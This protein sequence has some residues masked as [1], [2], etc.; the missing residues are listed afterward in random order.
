MIDFDTQDAYTILIVDDEPENLEIIVNYA[1]DSG[2]P[3]HILQSL[4]AATA[5]DIARKEQPHLVITDW[6]M[7]GENGIDFVKKLKGDDQTSDI[8]VIMCTGVMTSSEN[9]RTAFEAGAVDFIRKPID[10]IELISR[11]RSMLLLA[12]SYE[13][14]K[15]L[16]HKK[17]QLLS[18]IAHDLKAPVGNLNILTEFVLEE[19]L[20]LQEVRKFLQ[21]I[22]KDIGATYNLMDNLLSWARDQ[23]QLINRVPR[24]FDLFQAVTNA[25]KVF[26]S[27][28]SNKNI[29]IENRV[30][31]STWVLADENMISTVIRNLL[32][33]AIKFSFPDS[34]V[35]LKSI[36]LEHK[37]KLCVEDQGAGM[38]EEM[39][40]NLFN[41]NE[42][43]STPGTSSEKGFGLGLVL[44]KN[45]VEQNNGSIWLDTKEGR[46]TTFCFTVP[47]AMNNE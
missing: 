28:A 31:A 16:S 17:D 14:I 8:P 42:F 43:V 5:F 12:D 15:L 37:A 33:N 30:V 44:S 7:P 27:L 39:A 23:Q 45:F 3:Y 13:Q 26:E 47:L 10:K 19:N 24:R 41:A 40:A 2:E 9:L 6:D 22:R 18:I 32:S 34:V 46:G 1:E 35:V 29:R 4:N 20:S 11:M 25:V 38:D 36:T 21:R